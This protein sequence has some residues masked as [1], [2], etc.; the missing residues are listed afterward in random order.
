MR[1]VGPQ[2][3]IVVTGDLEITSRAL[4]GELVVTLPVSKNLP[5]AAAYAALFANPLAGAGV[6]VAERIFRDQID[7]YSSARYRIGG[8]VDE[9]EVVFDTI[10]NNEVGVSE[11][12]D[13]GVEAPA[14]AGTGPAPNEPLAAVAEPID[15]SSE[16]P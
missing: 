6:M 2:S 8:T 15:S 14:E 13:Q 5:W 10:F 11:P 4:D 3:S 12:A 1:I 9:P 16:E 7:K